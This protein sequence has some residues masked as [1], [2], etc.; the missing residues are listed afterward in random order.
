MAKALTDDQAREIVAR[1][2]LGEKQVWSPDEEEDVPPLVDTYS[3]DGKTSWTAYDCYGFPGRLHQ[4]AGQPETDLDIT[5]EVIS[6]VQAL[7]LPLV[8]YRA[9][10][11]YVCDAYTVTHYALPSELG[12]DYVEVDGWAFSVDTGSGPSGESVADDFVKLGE[13]TP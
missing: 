12:A 1:G 10:R 11:V 3:G 6:D 9:Y 4:Y 7:R 8:L 13:V 5:A 2:A